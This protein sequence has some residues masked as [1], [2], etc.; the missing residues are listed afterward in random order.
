MSTAIA[1]AVMAPVMIS[2]NVTTYVNRKYESEA[3]NSA[4]PA[5]ANPPPLLRSFGEA[6]PPLL[7]SFGEAGPPLLRS[8]GEAGPPLLRSFGEAGASGDVSTGRYYRQSHEWQRTA[9]SRHHRHRRCLPVRRRA[10]ALLAACQRRLQRHPQDHAVRRVGVSLP[11][12]GVGASGL[13]ER[14]AGDRWRRR[15]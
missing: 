9:R 6:G 13:D 12:G 5:H 11:G 2:P 3:A 1:R 14:R 8:F 15:A 4:A 10:R 7:R